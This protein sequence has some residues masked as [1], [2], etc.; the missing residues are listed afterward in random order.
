MERQVWRTP[1][2]GSLDRLKLQS[3]S[4]SAPGPGEVRVAVRAVGLNFADVFALLGLYSATPQGSFIPGLE[5]A[6]VV[7]ACGPVAQRDAPRW[8]PGDRV[9]GVIRFGAYAT[10]VNVDGRYLQP[11]PRRWSFAEGAALVAQ[12]LTAYYALYD[13]G[14]IRPGQSVLVHSAA[15]GVG[16]QALSMIQAAGAKAI[17]TIGRAEK[18]N[19]L[20]E[21]TGLRTERI[22][23]RDARRFGDQLDTALRNIDASGFDLILDSVAGPYFQPGY[24]R[25]HPA[26]RLILFGAADFMPEGRRPNYLKLAYQYLRRP[27]LDPVAMISE[28][29]SLMAFNL[30]CLWERVDLMRALL[31]D[32]L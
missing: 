8:K 7:E 1:G 30:I 31:G 2:A 32:L 18:I 15:G 22:I 19:I 14:S 29:K 16:L 11:L 24:R 25:L 10:H 28:N 3:E 9:F 17:A 12:G 6:G 5:F 23:V 26:G 4:L 20:R 21:Q 27:R 13:L